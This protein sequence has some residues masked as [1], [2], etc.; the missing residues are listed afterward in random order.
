MLYERISKITKTKKEKSNQNEKKIY[1][2]IQDVI[3]KD[4]RFFFKNR[5]DFLQNFLFSIY[6][7]INRDETQFHQTKFN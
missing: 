1:Q 5:K 6:I 2:Y 4:G 7:Y 3:P